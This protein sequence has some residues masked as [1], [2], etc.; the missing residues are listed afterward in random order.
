MALESEQS[1]A[2][3]SW[4]RITPFFLIRRP[5]HGGEMPP[6]PARREIPTEREARHGDAWPCDL[7]S[8]IHVASMGARWPC[9]G[10][11]SCESSDPRDRRDLN[12]RIGSLV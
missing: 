8:R 4:P 1:R 12:R 11:R 6:Q 10:N 9:E 5:L 2:T 3:S 7:H